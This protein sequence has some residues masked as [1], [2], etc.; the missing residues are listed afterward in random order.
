MW[1]IKKNAKTYVRFSLWHLERLMTEICTM[2]ICK[3]TYSWGPAP[4]VFLFCR[5]V[6]T[7]DDR[8]N[9]LTTIMIFLTTS[10]FSW[11]CQFLNF[12]NRTIIKGDIGKNVKQSQFSYNWPK[13]RTN[14]LISWLWNVRGPM[15]RLITMEYPSPH[16]LCLLCSSF[17]ERT[18]F[19]FTKELYNKR[20]TCVAHFLRGLW[21][22]RVS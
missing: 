10:S 3:Q 22:P 12:E 8:Q 2:K 17:Y 11:A 15:V 20:R 9:F 14:S 4:A 21:V 19:H 13:N 1:L 5:H 7:G 16:T 6:V 18:I